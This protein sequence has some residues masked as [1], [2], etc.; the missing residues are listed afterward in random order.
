M[1]RNRRI[2][3]SDNTLSAPLDDTGDI[4]WQGQ[5]LLTSECQKRGKI[6]A[7]D[8]DKNGNSQ[9]DSIAYDG[10]QTFALGLT[11]AELVHNEEVRAR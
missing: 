11:L 7:V 2:R 5:C 4:R 8:T 1:G 3:L 10:D 6:K 9:I